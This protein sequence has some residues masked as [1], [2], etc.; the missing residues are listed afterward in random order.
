M[1]YRLRYYLPVL[2]LAALV[3][4]VSFWTY[5]RTI[6]P[7]LGIVPDVPGRSSVKALSFG[8]E[9]FFFRLLALQIQISGDTF[10]RSTALYKYDYKK[11]NQWFI[12]LDSLDDE[13]DFVPTMASF[14]FSQ[15]QNR[16]DVRYVV[17]YLYTHA[18][19]RPQKKWW[20]L[21][22]A[23]YLANH[24]LKDKDLA[25]Q[26]AKPL[27]NAGDDVPIFARQ[28]PAFIHEQRGEFDD[29][30][31]IM[32]DIQKNHKNLSAGELNFMK[33]FV[34][35]RL[36]RLDTVTKERSGAPLRAQ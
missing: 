19:H 2:F 4:Q 27:E 8:D 6:K 17:D 15:T 3:I 29:A 22:Q 12:L 14:Y 18:A 30:L 7:D 25:L 35:E 28:M 5:S 36:K 20:W 24:V 31:R 16:P 26:M 34:E 23:V 13:S 33:Y 21:V 9:Q 10:G 1:Q 11:L 32:Q